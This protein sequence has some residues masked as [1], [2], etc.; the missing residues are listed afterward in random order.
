MI[1]VM[2]FDLDG[3]LAK[4]GKGILPEDMEL[5]RKIEECGVTIAICSGKPVNYL[6]GFMRQVGLEHPVLL[7]E[8]GATIQFGV[9]LP[10]KQFYVLPHSQQAKQSIKFVEEKI[11][12]KL[13][14]MWYQPNMV[15]LTP[16]PK[17]EGEFETIAGIFEAYKEQILDVVIYRHI[18]SYDVTPVGVDKRAGLEYFGKLVNISP[19]EVV[20]VG[21]GVNDYPMFEYAGHAVGVNIKEEQ[22]VNQNFAT[23]TEAL[24]YLLSLVDK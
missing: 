18:D 15:G 5:L 19:E 8:N 7:G 20:A 6:C 24:K 16:F 9:D 22:R 12:E 3:T 21:D 10:P 17:D 2:V 1:K 11:A 14:D 4:L 13:P 23:S